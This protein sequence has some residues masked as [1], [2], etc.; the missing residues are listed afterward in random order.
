MSSLRKKNKDKVSTKHWA[1]GKAW[2]D[3]AEQTPWLFWQIHRDFAFFA[4]LSLLGIGKIILCELVFIQKKQNT[5]S[6]LQ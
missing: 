4:D 2:W 5:I 6:H 1:C 3:T